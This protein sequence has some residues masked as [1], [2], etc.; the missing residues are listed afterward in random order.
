MKYAKKFSEIIIITTPLIWHNPSLKKPRY[1]KLISKD[2]IQVLDAQ[3]SLCV[4]TLA[5][6]QLQ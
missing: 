4:R 1:L 2:V 5:D 6:Q 3:P